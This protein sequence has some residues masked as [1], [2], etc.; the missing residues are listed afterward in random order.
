M[1]PNQLANRPGRY[2]FKLDLSHLNF[3]CLKLSD[4][5]C[6]DPFVRNYEINLRSGTDQGTSD[7][8]DLRMISHDNTLAS[9]THHGAMHSRLVWIICGQT[10]LQ[11]DTIHAD[12]YFIVEH[13]TNSGNCDLTG[14]REPVAAHSAAGH[15]DF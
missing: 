13:L 15:D 1:L 12:K 3:L 2:R 14:E 11:M 5:F 9:L 8:S 4:N 6:R 10:A 7:I